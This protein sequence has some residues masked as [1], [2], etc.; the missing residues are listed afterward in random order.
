M[1]DTRITPNNLRIAR[2]SLEGI[3]NVRIL[4][5]WTWNEKV[6]LW[7]L[8]CELTV[9]EYVENP[10]LPQV[11]AWYVVT[12]PDYPM[13]GISFY[14]SKKNGITHTFQHQL[15]NSK[16]NSD[17]PWRFGSLCLDINVKVLGRLFAD[18]E[19]FS[20][21][22]RLA[23][24]FQRALKWL[25]A[26]SNG[27]FTKPGEPFELPDFSPNKSFAL[28]FSENASSYSLWTKSNDNAGTVNLVRIN[29]TSIIA[30][31]SFQNRL[32]KP[33]LV[34]RWGKAIEAEENEYYKGLWIRLN[35][36]PVIEPWQPPSTFGELSEVLREQGFDFYE[37]IKSETSKIRDGAKHFL[38]LGFPI[39]ARYGKP[40]SRIHWQA[41]LLPVLSS[42]SKTM[43]GFRPNESGKILFDKL[44]IINH[45]TELDWIGSENWDSEQISTRGR[46]PVSLS[47][48]K[49]LIMGSGAVGSVVAELLIRG[50]INE[51]VLID[52]ED[53]EVG[54]L[55]RHTLGLE[56]IKK[57]KVQRLAKRL[58]SINPNSKVYSIVDN[59]PPMSDNDRATLKQC[60]V[61]IDCTGDDKALI[62]LSRFSWEKE[63]LII[64]INLNYGATKSFIFIYKGKVF[65]VQEFSQRIKPFLAN[66]NEVDELPS[67][68]IG[69]W[70]PV[71][72][73]RADDVWLLISACVK[74][75]LNS[76][77]NP[78]NSNT[79]RFTVFE[80]VLENN[81]FV[82]VRKI[83]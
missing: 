67:D 39:P 8:H 7:A 30:A 49:V 55:V 11:T 77:E 51:V 61:I 32:G 72:P 35:E 65:P 80:Q 14:P 21:E 17:L 64:S 19:P 1:I 2:R 9:S 29:N 10:F 34:P 59:F 48:Q 5:D 26:A 13:G 73:A 27:E 12:S 33:I 28:A 78:I 46:F 76:F 81:T 68:G 3:S 50:N 58:N 62:S 38:L 66:M 4:E 44:K 36:L 75:I 22:E 71:F 16:V 18:M 24:Y 53:F 6:S 15:N 45:N 20:V 37:M 54:N 43:K 25:Q 60:D 74:E 63:K 42:G 41:I 82:G 69:C 57:P 31:T 83:G 56:D 52:G 79:S 70:H 40:P 23:W 47:S